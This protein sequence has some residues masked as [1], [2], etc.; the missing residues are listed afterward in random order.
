MQVL[1]DTDSCVLTDTPGGAVSGGP[2]TTLWETLRSSWLQARNHPLC[3]EEARF[4]HGAPGCQVLGKM[5]S[6]S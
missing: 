3:R 6:W 4:H 1:M 5:P 2:W